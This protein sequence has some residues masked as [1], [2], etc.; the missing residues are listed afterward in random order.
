MRNYCEFS[1]L[2]GKTITSIDGLSSNHVV[3]NTE[4]GNTYQM[5]HEQDC[6]EHVYL[7][8]VYGA[9]CYVI[10][11][12]IIYANSYTSDCSGEH[13]SGTRTTFTITTGSGSLILIWEGYS[14]GY[15]GEGVSFYEGDGSRW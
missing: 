3:I 8:H 15:Y 14:N 6:C 13:G 12:P 2:V 11:E 1:D 5:H 4:C 9:E 7:K 10:N